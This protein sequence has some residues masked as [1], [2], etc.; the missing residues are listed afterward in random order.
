[1]HVP[2]TEVILRHGD[3]ELARV[4]LP[5]G[6]YVI[7]RGE[8]AQI[9]AET[10]LI[11]RRHAQLSIL[12]DQLLLED[13]GSSNG[14]FV[15]EQ[16]I[17]EST[18]LF[19]NQ[20]VRLG[21]VVLEVHRE[22]ARTEAGVTLHPAQAAVRRLLPDELLAQKRYAIGTQVARGGMG[23]IM[24]ARQQATQRDVAMK[25]MLES[26]NEDGAMRFIDEAQ[27]T[28]QLEHPNIVPIYELG[29]DEQDQLF[30]TMKFV[31][32]ITLKK[33]LELL[34]Q[35]IPETVKKY[36]LS[37]LLTIF[38]KTCDALA[39]AHARGVIH[40]DLKPENLMLG[41]FGEVLVMDWGLAK[42]L[43]DERRMTNDG[44]A[45]SHIHPDH[46]SPVSRHSA[47]SATMAGAIMGTPQ[48]MSPE[49]ARGEIETLD[50]RSDVYALGA[51]LFEI[52]YLRPP[53][54]GSDVSLIVSKVAQGVVEW[55][56]SAAPALPHL[57]GGR[58][59]DSLLAVCRKALAAD[60]ARRYASV[61]D[62]QRDLEAYQNGF[63]T[64]AE[65]AGAW[66]QFR[67]LI[68][69][70][71]GVSTA[72]AAAIV[73]VAAVTGVFT[74]NV[75]RARNRA[76]A[77]LHDLRGTAPT[78]AA[79]A[80]ALVEEGKLDEALEKISYATELDPKNADYLLQRANG[81]QIALHLHDA[82]ATYRKVLEVRPGD[83]A[84][85]QN[86]D[87]CERLLAENGG[88]DDLPQPVLVKLVDA[89][90]A[91]GRQVE[92]NPLAQRVGKGTATTEAALHAR[93]KKIIAQPGWNSG[94]IRAQPNGT[95]ALNFNSLH[96]DDLSALQGFPVSSL[97]VDDPN[98]HDV[99]PLAGL[100][101]VHL[102]ISNTG[103]TDLAPLAGL[104][105][106]SL[107]MTRVHLVDFHPLQ[108][109]K[110]R[111]LNM[112]NAGLTD[113]RQLAGL[114]LEKLDLSGNNVT[115]VTLLREMP[116]RDLNLS[117]NHI[118]DLSPIADLPLESLTIASMDL[119]EI[120]V[121][122]S[123]QLHALNMSS[124][125]VTNLAP[126]AGLKLTYLNLW[127]N[128]V[129]DLTPLR[130]MP[131]QNIDLSTDQRA[132]DL[133]AL[134]DCREL[135]EITLPRW[136]Y[137]E[138]VLR[139]LPKLRR[140]KLYP[141]QNFNLPIKQFWADLK[142]EWVNSAHARAIIQFS[143]LKVSAF[144]PV[145]L[146][147]D[148]TLMLDLNHADGGPIPSFAGLPISR[149]NLDASTFTDLSP[150][151]GLPLRRLSLTGAPVG[152]LTPLAGMALQS[153]SLNNTKVKDL[154]PL[155]GMPL[156]EIYVSSLGLTDLSF[157]RSRPLHRLDIGNNPVTDIS[158]LA[159]MPLEWL[160]A[161]GTDTADITALRGMPLKYLSLSRSR[162]RDFAPLRGMPLTELN[163]EGLP[164]Q[165]LSPL[166]DLPNLQKLRISGNPQQLAV[167]RKHPTLK[168]IALGSVT[169]LRPV[170]AFWA[171]YDADQAKRR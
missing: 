152:D 154:S 99:A 128:S 153:L 127:G 170:V 124:D 16:R 98:F 120:P 164:A 31:R 37:A 13:L 5:P 67:L 159:G 162:V 78:F 158:V 62:L 72:I 84:T 119:S 169:P 155:R 38:Q 61:T 44:R 30:Y 69:R 160:V 95:F 46:S 57:P 122:H 137:H 136:F 64:S 150:L 115:D 28:A 33:V 82:M 25:V 121:L 116:L 96:V 102:G 1:M 112:N 139:S 80:R 111:E 14:T 71:R 3:T 18:R 108:G 103:V 125:R 90:L 74:I 163:A 20:H 161:S 101:L 55:T 114:H 41:D 56:T 135:E 93:L 22:R 11:S 23:A 24:Q 113:L 110:L 166:L 141:V 143:G 151:H 39:F 43:N 138:E 29:V 87:L 2:Q 60:S 47:A 35:G 9:Y 144:N 32:G 107:S 21:D 123:R 157:L 45:P 27:V 156:Q 51:I 48:Y 10:P 65:K 86:L 88:R 15:A 126:L 40:R 149:L 92:A 79:Q 94:R 4:T 12:Y 130:G 34:E 17:T 132:M 104:P 52:I 19:P 77:A 145:N 85:Q 106:E 66:K 148:G 7:G 75:V 76:E 140:A 171:E 133:S 131:L 42:K 49:Q 91:Q 147:P 83:A 68:Q 6:E 142:P 54:G 118:P 105:L 70:N 165:D 146:D 36:P 63:A 8:E 129:T 109:M 97:D 117:G 26:Q 100:P 73:I 58:A 167:L 134:T 50:A 59:P 168:F 81:L 53:V 89:L